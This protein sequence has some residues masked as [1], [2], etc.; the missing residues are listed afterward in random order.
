[1]PENREYWDY[2]SSN[3]IYTHSTCIEVLISKF[4]A[5]LENT[6]ALPKK[7]EFGTYVDVTACIPRD[8]IK[9][10]DKLRNTL[11][12]QRGHIMKI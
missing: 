3:Y 11:G 8:I 7:V 12:R 10:G 6:F 1:M 2:F 5:T 4:V 9:P